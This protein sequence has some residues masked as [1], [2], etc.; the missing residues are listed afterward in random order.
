MDFPGTNAIGS[1][2]IFYLGDAQHAA[3]DNLTFSD[4]R[5]LLATE[6][7]GDGLHEQ[8][9]FLD[10]IWA[11]DVRVGDPNP[12]R[13]VALGRDDFATQV[14][15]SGGEGD[16]EPTGLHV[17]DGATHN[18][19][20]GWQT[21]VA[22]SSAMV[23]H[24]A[25]WAE[26]GVRNRPVA[27]SGLGARG[28]KFSLEPQAFLLVQHLVNERDRDRA[29]AD[30]GRD[31]LDVA[32]AHV[33]DRED[34]GPARFEQIRRPR[35]RP[36]RPR[37]ILGREVRAGLDEAFVVERDAAGRATPCSARRRSS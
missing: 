8:L 28:L 7:R 25:A 37:Q 2:S 12:R 27:A 14:D 20:N 16:N 24:A 13:L 1:I 9:N 6:D 29:F 23:L 11:F 35:Q 15:V 19:A 32:A 4:T 26:S 33:A 30:R 3:F 10:S 5:T 21:N 22:A 31:A 17:S 36:S 18:P 34:A